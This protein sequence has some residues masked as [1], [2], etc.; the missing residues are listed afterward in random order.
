MLLQFVLSIRFAL[1]FSTVRLLMNS[2]SALMTP[3]DSLK[4]YKGF[5]HSGFVC[6][7]VEMGDV[8]AYVGDINYSHFRY[9]MAGKKRGI[10]SQVQ[11][12]ILSVPNAV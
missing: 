7:D 12:P 9:D 10:V 1:C 6:M 8:K 3:L 2:W 5:L 11:S 4:Y